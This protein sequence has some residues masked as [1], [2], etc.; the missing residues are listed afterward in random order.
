MGYKWCMVSAEELVV[1]VDDHGRELGTAAKAAVHH[2]ATPLH[3]GFSCYVFDA[4]GRAA[5][6]LQIGPLRSAVGR[7]ERAHYIESLTR[8][9]REL[10][11]RTGVNA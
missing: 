3:L 8:T 2:T 11:T 10:D 5:W 6:E 1:L 9:A 7:D 4:D